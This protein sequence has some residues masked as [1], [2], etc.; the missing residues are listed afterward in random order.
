MT[1]ERIRNPIFPFTWCGWD[2][3]HECMIYYAV[4]F[5]EDFGPWKKGTKLDHMTV[6]YDEGRIVQFDDNGDRVM[7]A[8]FQAKVIE[9][10]SPVPTGT[11]VGDLEAQES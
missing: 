9:Y 8:Q 11:G 1:A 7:S 3:D 2:G 6:E 5:E 4:I 10:D